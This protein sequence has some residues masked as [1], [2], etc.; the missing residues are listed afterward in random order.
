MGRYSLSSFAR[1]ILS[2][3]CE[4]QGGYSSATKHKVQQTYLFDGVQDIRFPC[5]ISVGTD[6]QVDFVW[7]FVSLERL[8][9][10]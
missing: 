3:A 2:S 4:T 10:T 6:T 8:S 9:D 7:V 1:E 5:F